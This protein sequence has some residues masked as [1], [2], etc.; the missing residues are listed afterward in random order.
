MKNSASTL[1][2]NLFTR[3][4]QPN[5]AFRTLVHR[6]LPNFDR[7]AHGEDAKGVAN[8]LTGLFATSLK[9]TRTAA[10]SA[11][12][13]SLSKLEGALPGS[14]I[15]AFL[16]GAGGAA[17]TVKDEDASPQQ[18][19][20][21]ILVGAG[22]GSLGGAGTGVLARSGA[23]A[24]TAGAKNINTRL[25]GWDALTSMG[26]MP[27]AM[28]NPSAGKNVS[29]FQQIKQ[30]IREGDKATVD[31]LSGGDNAAGT[32]FSGPFSQAMNAAGVRHL[33]AGYVINPDVAR[34]SLNPRAW[35]RLRTQIP[36][37]QTFRGRLAGLSQLDL[38]NAAAAGPVGDRARLIAAIADEANSTLAPMPKW[39]P[40]RSTNSLWADL[41]NRKRNAPRMGRVKDNLD[42]EEDAY[43]YIDAMV[44]RGGR[45]KDVGLTRDQMM[46]V[47]QRRAVPGNL[48]SRYIWDASREAE[49]AARNKDFLVNLFDD[50]DAQVAN[51]PSINVRE[52]TP[53]P[54][55]VRAA[56]KPKRPQVA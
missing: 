15:G 1:L 12:K 34:G 21:N 8:L 23:K 25:R 28:L 45:V 42:A 35:Q 41:R 27:S 51:N 56:K 17:R 9:G 47:V 52:F 2:R 39:T 26:I 18:L 33:D 38:G 29:R 7:L 3:T 31:V 10:T 53:P 6:Q 19:I 55:R 11:A 50:L 49:D 37:L 20:R 32:L 22:A 16:G 30:L 48:N 46:D 13:E 24:L 43:D 14:A 36:G 4:M 54:P 5:S 40:R 44:G